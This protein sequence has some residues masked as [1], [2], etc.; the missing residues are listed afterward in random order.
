MSG[1]TPGPV[2]LNNNDNALSEFAI[3]SPALGRGFGSS[4]A[5]ASQ[6]DGRISREQA[7][8]NARRLAACWNACEGLDT[9]LLENILMLGDTLKTRFDALTSRLAE[10]E[11]AA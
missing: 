10:L 5:V 9:E 8:A 6:R 3:C 2:V 11:G 4:L 1:H 7:L